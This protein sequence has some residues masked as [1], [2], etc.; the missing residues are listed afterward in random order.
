M[1]RASRCPQG[2]DLVVELRSDAHWRQSQRPAEHRSGDAAVAESGRI[3]REREILCVP[4]EVIGD[5]RQLCMVQDFRPCYNCVLSLI[6][7][8]FA[9]LKSLHI[10]FSLSVATLE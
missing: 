8:M 1:T 7:V 4:T 2:R 6:G 9:V 3:R 10:R 5:P